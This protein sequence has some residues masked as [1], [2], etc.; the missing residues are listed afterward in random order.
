MA[1]ANESNEGDE[2]WQ[3]SRS[4]SIKGNESRD[5]HVYSVLCVRFVSFLMCCSN[6]Q[7]ITKPTNAELVQNAAGTA[8]SYAALS[9][10]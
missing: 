6:T 1:T 8:D 5:G 9:D 3:E 7:H 10:E 2:S 4:A